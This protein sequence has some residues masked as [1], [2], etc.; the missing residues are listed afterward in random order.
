MIEHEIESTYARK[1]DARA[2]PM[3]SPLLIMIASF[4]L[5]ARIHDVAADVADQLGWTKLVVQKYVE[6]VGVRSLCDRQR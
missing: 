4:A 5:V 3:S 1:Q 2:C 6:R